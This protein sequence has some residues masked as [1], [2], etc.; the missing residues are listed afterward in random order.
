[1]LSLPEPRGAL[2]EA[3]LAALQRPVHPL[4]PLPPPDPAGDPLADEDL[5]LALY[6]CYELHYRGL[7]GVDESWEGEPSL[8][9]LRRELEARF[10]IGLEAL[11]GTPAAERITPEEVDVA[12]RA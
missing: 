11:S 12:L 8:L 7:P 4:E 5:Q 2:T 6:C 3:L 10:E 1:M 9:A